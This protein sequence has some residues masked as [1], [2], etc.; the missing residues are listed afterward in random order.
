MVSVV[1]VL[2][3]ELQSLVT[4]DLGLQRE[5]LMPSFAIYYVMTDYRRAS[6]LTKAS[7]A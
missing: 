5:L 6:V 4:A 3:Q 1:L 2:N 7:L